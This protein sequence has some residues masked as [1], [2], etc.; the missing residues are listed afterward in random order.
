MKRIV[1]PAWQC[2]SVLLDTEER[3]G[4]EIDNVIRLVVA[5]H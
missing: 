3:P 4:N 1:V 2:R 5:F